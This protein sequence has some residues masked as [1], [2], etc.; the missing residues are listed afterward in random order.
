MKKYLLILSIFISAV[1]MAQKLQY[2]NTYGYEYNRFA[3]RTLLGLPTDTFTVDAG[4][5][6]IPW[7]ANKLGTIYNWNIVTHVWDVL[8]GGGGSTIYVNAPLTKDVDTINIAEA[9]TL[10]DG[11]LSAGNFIKFDSIRNDW[12]R[13]GN[14]LYPASTNDT[15]VLGVP[16]TTLHQLNVPGNM[17][18]GGKV[19]YLLN[20]TLMDFTGQ[21][22]F[23]G[24]RSGNTTYSGA[25][26]NAGFGELALGGIT[27]G[28]NNAALGKGAGFTITTGSNWIVIGR[29]V[30]GSGGAGTGTNNVAIGANVADPAASDQ[31]NFNN[32][33]YGLSGRLGIGAITSAF[34]P[35]ATLDIDSAV[36]YPHLRLR[37]MAADPTTVNDGN[38]W[39]T[40]NHFYA[41]LNGTTRQLDQQGI[42]D[43]LAVG[44][45]LSTNRTLNIGANVLTI[46]GTGQV[47]VTTSTSGTPALQ[48]I[49]QPS[50]TNTV[51]PVAIFRRNT[52]GTAA[53]NIAGSIDYLIQNSTGSSITGA[54]YIWRLT[55]ATAG[56]EVSNVVVKG[57][58]GGASVDLLT[59]Q[60]AYTL[61]NN[62]A[63][64][65]ES[66][67]GARS[68]AETVTNKRNVRRI[69][70]IT[71]S[72]TPTPDGD[73]SDMF[74]VTALAV[75]ATFAAP[76]G[77]PIAGQ[78]MIIRIKDNGTAQ[79]LNW[80]A[81]YRAGTDVALPTTTVLGK[82]MYLG[83]IWNEV[84]LTWD[85]LTKL[86]GF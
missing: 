36:G 61:N 56:A 35:G 43:V 48:V 55:T 10:N 13:S 15:I 44:Q 70:T 24:G 65:L 8:A 3:A 66:R 79:T 38:F 42:D 23:V 52:T 72:A 50:T 33:M 40:G 1:S 26:E 53:T 46:G 85:L 27:S 16:T 57:L 39:H 2:V 84:S 45:S 4:I 82:V 22:A 59:M 81:I 63:D 21:N 34:T 67:S 30:H 12:Y 74:T 51:E 75:T 18:L 14:R 9:S 58:N 71:S 69:T 19:F 76:T 37:G 78:G 77:T 47:Q 73:A 6:N 28:D 41:R 68:R 17:H 80:N 32:W 86:D 64:T 20:R 11:Y 31:L 5:N 54:Q 83:I 25:V 49:N 60:P 62:G 29:N 7:M